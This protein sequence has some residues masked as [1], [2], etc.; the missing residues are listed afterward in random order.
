MLV[1]SP[2]TEKFGSMNES[3]DLAALLADEAFVSTWLAW[4]TFGEVQ[5][6]FS[7]HMDEDEIKSEC[8]LIKNQCQKILDGNISVQEVVGTLSKLDNHLAKA[9]ENIGIF[10]GNS[11]FAEI[12][13]LTLPEGVINN[14][15]ANINEVVQELKSP[16]LSKENLV[17]KSVIYIVL[18]N[19]VSL[20]LW[21]SLIMA[22]KSAEKY[23][24]DNETSD[25]AFVGAAAVG[26]NGEVIESAFR[27]EASPLAMHAED[28]LL[29][30]L[31]QSGKIAEVCIIASNLEPCNE[32]NKKHESALGHC[33]GCSELITETNAPVVAF[34]QTDL[35]GSGR[36]RGKPRLEEAGKVVFIADNLR[37][38][39]GSASLQVYGHLK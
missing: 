39:N 5:P 28:S 16:K 26:W 25:R 24:D 27:G 29:R 37:A 31:E 13:K 3:N 21:R 10:D 36:G 30:K 8:E 32:R 23:K 4:L 34:I 20:G 9:A 35:N 11:G 18:K 38:Q 1:N 17:K 6:E 19:M 14:L 15:K 33:K 7:D 2:F 22:T 12:L